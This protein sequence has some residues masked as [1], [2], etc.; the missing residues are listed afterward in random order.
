MG[1]TH[2]S[3]PILGQQVRIAPENTPTKFGDAS[4]PVAKDISD[5]SFI[6]ISSIIVLTKVSNYRLRPDLNIDEII[7]SRM[8]DFDL[9][10]LD[11][12]CT[13]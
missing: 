9:E 13:P 2:F 11:E 1:S 12:F 7:G 6:Y 3:A 8:P 10:Y 4:Y 5:T